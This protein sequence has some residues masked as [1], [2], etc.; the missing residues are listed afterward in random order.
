M[1]I[2][3]KFTSIVVFCVYCQQTLPLQSPQIDVWATFLY[4]NES[5]LLIKFVKVIEAL[6]TD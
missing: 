3:V 1:F 5:K 4:D 6:Q 2:V